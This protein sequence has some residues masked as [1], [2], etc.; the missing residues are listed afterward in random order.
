MSML[1]RRLMEF[2]TPGQMQGICNLRI[3]PLRW[4]YAPWTR[5]RYQIQQ[6]PPQNQVRN[7]RPRIFRAWWHT[8]SVRGVLNT[9]SRPKFVTQPPVHI[10][11]LG[12]I[13]PNSCARPIVHLKTPPNETSSPNTVAVSS[14]VSAVLYTP[15]IQAVNRGSAPQIKLR[16]L[17]KG[18]ANRIVH[19]HL[20]CL[21]AHEQPSTSCVLVRPHNPRCP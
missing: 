17:L 10:C 4:L 21:L 13:I 8:C 16:Y 3:E 19:V 14:L 2:C 20:L 7:L 1:V 15:T 6:F 12:R 11:L 18:I 9:R 5:A